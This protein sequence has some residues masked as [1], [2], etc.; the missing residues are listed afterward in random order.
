MW[1]SP[2]FNIRVIRAFDALS[3]GNVGQALDIAGT[4]AAMDAKQRIECLGMDLSR[5]VSIAYR[6]EQT[7]LVVAK[8]LELNKME[9]DLAQ[10]APVSESADIETGRIQAVIDVI[11]RRKARG[12]KSLTMAE[13]KDGVKNLKAF[14]GMTKISAHIKERIIPHLVNIGTVTMSGSRVNI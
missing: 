10:V 4:L 14:H 9:S 1:L 3:T 13:L 7:A 2:K 8:R 5:Q 12:R 11:E 6:D